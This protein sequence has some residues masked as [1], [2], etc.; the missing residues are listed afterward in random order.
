[1]GIWI[2]SRLLLL[3]IMPQWIPLHLSN[4]TFCPTSLREKFPKVGLLSERKSAFE[5]F[6]GI[7]RFLSVDGT[8]LQSYEQCVR[9][10]WRPRDSVA[11]LLYFFSYYKKSCI[12]LFSRIILNFSSIT[13]FYM[14]CV[15]FLVC[16]GYPS[17]ATSVFR[18]FKI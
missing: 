5:N 15:F 11:E 2:V 9:V 18:F 13:V 3:Q 8:I 7:T 1:M 6:L 17:P 4:F 12:S 10:S 16:C 14:F